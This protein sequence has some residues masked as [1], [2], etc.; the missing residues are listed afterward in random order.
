MLTRRGGLLGTL[1]GDLLA[2]MALSPCPQ[3]AAFSVFSQLKLFE[4]VHSES[5]TPVK[6]QTQQE[7]H[8]EN[9]APWYQQDKRENN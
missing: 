7:V 2:A 4:P 9:F 5:P 8:K 1:L 6:V 3:A